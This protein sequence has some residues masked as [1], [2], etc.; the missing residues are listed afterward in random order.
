[1]SG[2]VRD[3]SQG[4]QTT[5]L[6][7]IKDDYD[8]NHK[9]F[10]SG[11]QDFVA[12]HAHYHFTD[13]DINDYTNNINAYYAKIIDANDMSKKDY[14]RLI[15]KVYDVDQNYCGKAQVIYNQI[16]EF[17]RLV[18]YINDSFIKNKDGQYNIEL[19]TFG[20]SALF[21][22]TN[23]VSAYNGKCEYGLNPVFDK[24]GSYG[25]NQGEAASFVVG[26]DEFEAIAA[27]IRSYPDYSS[28]S[29]KEIDEF[30]DLMNNTGCGYIALT[31]SLFDRYIGREA[32]FEATFGYPMYNSSG[33][34]NYSLVFADIYCSAGLESG[35]SRGS[36]EEM[37]EEFCDDHN[38]DVNV[39]NIGKLN[40]DN[41]EGYRNDG[42][43]IV[44]ADGF[45]L[46][47]ENGNIIHK[48]VGAHAMAVT[49]V[50]ADGRIIISSWGDIYYM[51]PDSSGIQYQIVD[52]N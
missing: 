11:F 34:L 40:Q 41:F 49:G 30:L 5:I 42:Q 32:E 18:T 13:I 48:D 2:L 31:N 22:I 44:R 8:K 10:F 26:S 19:N 3:F 7:L 29:D 33:E 46:E 14:E 15:E 43:I 28:Y 21:N 50:A 25:G 4:T 38:V 12:D 45:N 39:K 23:L 52:Y 17:S 35:T 16:L 9:H 36:R 47:D 24:H 37:W 51:D 6:G 1:M 20:G 27:I